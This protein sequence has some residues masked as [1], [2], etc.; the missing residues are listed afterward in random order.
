VANDPPVEG[1][2]VLHGERMTLS[3]REY[4]FEVRRSAKGNR[5]LSVTEIHERNGKSRKETV[6]V[7]EDQMDEFMVAMNRA[8]SFIKEN[9]S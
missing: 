8:V 2:K 9:K 3:N 4:V 7:F 6:A 5:Y 1:A